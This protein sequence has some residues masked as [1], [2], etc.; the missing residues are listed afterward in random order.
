MAEVESSEVTVQR[1]LDAFNARDLEALLAT[2]A[3]DAEVYEHPSTL[4]AAGKDA[5]RQRY[6]ARLAEP[7]LRAD[8]RYRVVLGSKVIDHERVIR[9]FPEGEGEID[10]VM[11]YEVKAGRI[12]KAWSIAGARTLYSR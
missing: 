7:N 2:Y 12:A 8:L 3:D 5:L 11:I 10:L 4:I 6:A 9:T 1:Q